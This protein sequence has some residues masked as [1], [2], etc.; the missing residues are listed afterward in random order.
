[1]HPLAFTGSFRG[2]VCKERLWHHGQDVVVGNVSPKA[3]RPGCK[4]CTVWGACRHS[5]LVQAEP[6]A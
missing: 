5:G 3:L 1:M 6:W 4:R 2:H